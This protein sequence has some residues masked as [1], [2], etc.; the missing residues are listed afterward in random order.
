MQQPYG[1]IPAMVT[2]MNND[3]TINEEQLRFQVNRMIEAKVH[4][5]FCL[6]TNGEFYALSTEEKID[7]IRI[8]VDENKGRLPIYA[9]TGC[10]TTNETI[11]LSQKAQELG[12][13]AISVITPYFVSASQE[14]LSKHY[15]KIAHS[16]NIPLVLYN[17]PARTGNNIAP[18]TAAYL[19][20]ISNIVGIKDSSGNFE[21]ILNYLYYTD[22]DF[23]VLCGTDSLILWTLM[24]GGK[25]AITGIA[26]IVPETMVK[27]YESWK[28]GDMVKARK[29]QDSIQPIRQCI[30]MGNPN[31]I[32]KRAVNIL[33]YPV[34]P[35]REPVAANEKNIDEAIKNA[36]KKYFDL[37]EE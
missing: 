1:I 6:G 22:T 34:G 14:E 27:I 19:S 29:A 5:L 26:N 13:D 10:I 9:G 7:V 18:K 12:I 32:V 8:V 21:N 20:K 3:E 2:P 25:G 36:L 16:V 23:T 17:I 31:S 4:G 28:A 11:Y 37:M 35:A 24:A 33:G 30:S 15:E